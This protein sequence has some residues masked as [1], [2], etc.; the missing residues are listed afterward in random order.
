MLLR[1]R[2]R[3]I[4]HLTQ[5]AYEKL[6]DVEVKILERQCLEEDFTHGFLKG[7]RLVHLKTG[8]DI[9][10]LTPSDDAIESELKKVFSS[11]DDDV[12]IT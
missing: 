1:R 3:E 10:G 6:F 2:T 4:Q 7:V 9:E 11:D 8:V 5:A 12:E